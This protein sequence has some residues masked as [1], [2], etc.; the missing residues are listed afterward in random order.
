MHVV[1]G[2]LH[3]DGDCDGDGDGDGPPPCPTMVWSHES[4]SSAPVRFVQ[5]HPNIFVCKHRQERLG[6]W[7]LTNRQMV[8]N[9][10]L[11]HLTLRGNLY[12]Q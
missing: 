4:V 2:N 10:K 3:C 6:E 11:S 9:S 5:W 8:M 1:V 7:P 12:N